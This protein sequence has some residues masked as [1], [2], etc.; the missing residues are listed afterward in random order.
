MEEVQALCRRVGILDHG[1][2]IACDE[3][4]DLLR[5][6]D[7]VIRFRVPRP[8]PAVRE[9]LEALAGKLHED[10]DGAFELHAADVQ[11]A[12]M[13]LLALLNDENVHVTDLS[14]QEPNLERVFLH[15]TGREL[16]D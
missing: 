7:G 13:R 5:T 14:V 2:L 8:A 6:L 16:R 10:G 12:L 11:P 1:R 9:R 15:L 4:P 3:L